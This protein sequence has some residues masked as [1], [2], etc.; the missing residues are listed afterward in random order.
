LVP[1]SP[2]GRRLRR[3]PPGRIAEADEVAAPLLWLLSNEARL[4]TGA[5]LDI[6]GGGF[7]FAA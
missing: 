2:D 1:V 6:S 5:M 4:I 7:T 3:I